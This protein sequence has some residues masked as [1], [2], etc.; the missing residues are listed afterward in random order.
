MRA[1]SRPAF[2]QAAA[3]CLDYPDEQ[4]FARITLFA[5]GA[6]ALRP[7]LEHAATVGQAELAEHY[8][9][10]FDF[11]NRHCLH[12]TWWLDGDTRRRGQSLVGLKQAYREHGMELLNEELPDYLP[13]VLEFVAATGN[14]DLL[15]E[16]RPGLELLRL[17][18]SDVD[19]PYAQVVTALC[20]TLPG[21]SPRDRAT[22]RALARS[23][24]RTEDVGLVPYGHLD[25]LPLLT[26]GER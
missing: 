20:A 10:T 8:V 4:F 7:F 24:P 1:R 3:H 21:P 18:L 17:A 9:H 16:H 13:V 5:A 15:L 25:L 23:G 12:L 14:R 2:Y 19:T 11:H 26:S 22:A 6:P